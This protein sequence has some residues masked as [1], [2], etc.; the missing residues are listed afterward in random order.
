MSEL[1]DLLEGT[2]S[3]G[4]VLGDGVR[5]DGPAS[6]EDQ[7]QVY[8]EPVPGGWVR[9]LQVTARGTDG[10]DRVFGIRTETIEPEEEGTADDEPDA[11]SAVDAP[12]PPD[13]GGSVSQCSY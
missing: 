6:S 10:T 12:V 7:Y 2:E 1:R 4:G 11:P 3:H 8:L 9:H 5:L 13:P